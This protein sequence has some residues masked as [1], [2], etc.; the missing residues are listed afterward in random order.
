MSTSER[1][2]ASAAGH[3]AAEARARAKR[4]A[5]RR[6]GFLRQILRWHWISAAICLIGMLLFAIT[7][8][9]LNHAGSIPA[10]PRVTERTAELPPSLLPLLQ[11][12]EADG[13]ALPQ[14]VRAWIGEALKVR[15]PADAQPEWSPGE[16]YLALPRPGGDAWLT[17][18]TAA[19]EAIYE[20]TDRGV[21]AYLND[22]HKGRNT[23]TA[24]MWF[25]DIFA[26]GCVVFCVTGLI[27]LQL[28][29]HA[30]RSTWPLV[31]AGLIIPL[32]LAL[33]FIH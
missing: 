7:G 13:T 17:L 12:A 32:L 27:L 16:L 26:I 1:L 31:G 24:W 30:R 15:V 29:A 14:P 9:T 23:G 8:I 22:L 19:G 6:A 21:V 5:Q 4:Q 18:D 2:G 33:L 10:T 28:H 20:R 3:D 11:A 25:L